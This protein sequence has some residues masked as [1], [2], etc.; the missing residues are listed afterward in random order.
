MMMMIEQSRVLLKNQKKIKTSTSKKKPKMDTL[1][2]P[3]FL[4]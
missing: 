1:V 4:P 2:L 3:P